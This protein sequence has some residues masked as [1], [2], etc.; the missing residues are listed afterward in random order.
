[1]ETPSIPIAIRM[2]TAGALSDRAAEAFP[3]SMA[4]ER[5]ADFLGREHAVL[6]MPEGFGRSGEDFL[7]WRR[8]PAGRPIREG[9]IPQA[10]VGALFLQAAA[11]SAWLEAAG[12]WLDDADLGDAVWEDAE[13]LPRLELPR[14]PAALARG[15]SAPAAAVLAAFLERVRGRTRRGREPGAGALMDLLLAPEAPFRRAEFWVA[16]A[17]RAFPALSSASAA[18]VRLRTIGRGARRGRSPSELARVETGRALLAGRYPRVF[19]IQASALAPGAALGLEPMPATAAGAARELRHRHARE[20]PEGGAVWIAVEPSSWDGFSRRAFDAAAGALRNQV[21]IVTLERSPPAPRGTGDWRREIFVPCGT[22]AAALRFSEALAERAGGEDA[23]VLELARL[24]VASEEWGAFVADPTGQAPLPRTSRAAAPP[25][26]DALETN[27]AE[28]DLLQL[29]AAAPRAVPE[30]EIAAAA[31]IACAEG[32]LRRLAECGLAREEPSRRWLATRAGIA[33]A[34]LSTASRREICRRWAASSEDR[35][36]RVEWLLEA[37]EVD[38]ALAEARDMVGGNGPPER[39]FEVS[40]RLAARC[41]TL[42]GWLEALEAEREVAGGRPSEARSRLTRLLSRA[43]AGAEETR[44]A[45]LRSAEIAALLGN[46]GEAGR[47]AAAWLRAHGGAPAAERARALRLEAAAKS[48]VG[49]FDL[50]LARVDEAERVSAGLPLAERLEAGLARAAIYSAAGRLREEA[51]TYAFWRGAVLPTGE[52][53]LAARLFATEALG[54]ADRRQFPEA[55]ARLEE[56]LAACR[57]DPAEAARL[58]IDL[59]GT[60]YHA[61]RPA[62][63]APLLDEAIRDAAAAGREDLVHIALGNAIE[64][65]IDSGDWDGA[66]AGIARSVDD[67]RARR[68]ERRLLVALHQRSRLALR[69]G[70]LA[71]AAADNEAAVEIAER[72][73]DR[74]EAGELRLE[75]G[76]LAVHAGDLG[77]AR[78]AYELAAADPPDRCD[79]DVRARERLSELAWRDAGGIPAAA[80]EEL[81]REFAADALAAAERAARWAALLPGGGALPSRLAALAASTLRARGAGALADRAFGA[82]ADPLGADFLRPIRAAVAQA[83]SGH[84]GAALPPGVTGLAVLDFDGRE[85]ASVG[86]AAPDGRCSRRPLES[87]A[88][89]YELRVWPRLDAVREDA[90]AWMV[91]TLLYRPYT[92][93]A[94]SDFEEGWRRLGVVT[95]DASMEEPYRRLVRFAAQPVTVLVRGESGTGKEAVARAVHALSPRAAGP[96]VAVNVPAIPAAL[97]ESELF[98]HVKGAFTGAERD[99]AGLLEAAS[100]GTIFFDE[101]AD[102]APSL[103]SKLLR[104]LQDR[105]IRRV[106]ENRSRRIDVRVVSATSRDLAREVE[107]GRFRQDLFYRLNVAL[108]ALPALRDRGSDVRVLARHFLAQYAREFRRGELRLDPD[109]AAAL[110]SHGWPGNVRE[111]QNAIAQAAALADA[112]GRVRRDHLPEPVRRLRAAAAPVRNYRARLDAH[113][114]SLISDALQRSGG[115]RSRAAR[116][117][118]LSRQAL[119]YLIRELHISPDAGSWPTANGERRR[120]EN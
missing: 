13:G 22:A 26:T 101:I 11:A 113:R 63:A 92:P 67:A 96:F 105:E 28:R 10:H 102:L 52:D 74:L 98:G 29:L 83:L 4:R 82:T 61:G 33:R 100:G 60:L 27:P 103:Q 88:A 117:L 31:G 73:C 78:R 57:D 16:S 43:E 93:A 115:N 97:L 38:R 14:S 53:A 71:D 87:G 114:R 41:E 24:L 106:G 104:A 85:V 72:L 44:R 2:K 69:R 70:E 116:E 120:A 42:P 68:D 62:A 84:P 37:G 35:V 3:L 19:E 6:P 8:P 40:A 109:A 55:I 36:R 21:E 111:L 64:L 39:W 119:A 5:W 107:A 25:R 65:A 108:V 89:A 99:R 50:A 94:P 75:E 66:A 81:E 46:A 45:A 86:T 1:M 23:D 30:T 58:R 77:R 12:L 47:E 80:L 59:A 32:K 15:G 18:P 76:D 20:A 118:G 90:I 110:A 34:A 51:E 79:S 54:L 91:E 9:R 95:A 49:E 48:R 17:F 112:D 56:A 7:V